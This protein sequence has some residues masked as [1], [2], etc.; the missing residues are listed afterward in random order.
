MRPIKNSYTLLG[1]GLLLLGAALA[2]VSS[3]I[4][5]STPLTAL[6]ISAFILGA[7]CV[8][9]A[10]TRP[11][12]SPEVSRVLL[13]TGLENTAS[14][15][16][17]LGLTSRAI[18]LPSSLAGEGG[19]AIIPLTGAHANGL[20]I[21]GR[22]PKRLIVKYGNADE[23][24]GIRVATAGA[25]CLRLSGGTPG[26]GSSEIE[27]AVTSVIVG[28]LDVADGVKV[29]ISKDMVVAQIAKPRLDY[30]N[31]KSHKCLGS[32][33][34]SIVATMVCE[35]LAKPVMITRESRERGRLTVEMKVVE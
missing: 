17:E 10:R 25:A 22:I 27:A 28:A 34:A 5:E 13:E 8:A 21:K 2:L 15:V 1:A 29:N 18:Y 3:F 16:E 14:L 24:V 35:G 7:I 23:N 32:P 30:R 26:P 9:L 11:N 33:L 12:I 6:G 31:V 20:E 19:S 4:L